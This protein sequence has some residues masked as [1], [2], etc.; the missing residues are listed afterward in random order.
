MLAQP[1]RQSAAVTVHQPLTEKAWK[2][3]WTNFSGTGGHALL[4][5]D[6]PASADDVIANGAA[7]RPN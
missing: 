5:A 7:H 1:G 4:R 2:T 6:S 3:A